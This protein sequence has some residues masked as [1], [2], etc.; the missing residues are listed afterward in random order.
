MPAEYELDILVGYGIIQTPYINAKTYRYPFPTS[1]Q[2]LGDE[3]LIIKG[4]LDSINAILH[5]MYW[6][7]SDQVNLSIPPPL[8]TINVYYTLKINGVANPQHIEVLQYVPY[9]ELFPYA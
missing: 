6:K 4:S 3:H 7:Y 9:T 2:R 5:T 1:I 8:Q